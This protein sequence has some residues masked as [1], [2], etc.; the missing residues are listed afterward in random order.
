MEFIREPGRVWL[1]GPDGRALAWVDFPAAGEN[2]VDISR[3]FVDE[4]LRGQGVAAGLLAQAA[5][6]LRATGRKARP[7]CS[8]AVKWFAEHPEY[9]DILA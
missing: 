3:T 9:Q 7:T 2:I 1:P 4:S 5:A 6:L 8:Y